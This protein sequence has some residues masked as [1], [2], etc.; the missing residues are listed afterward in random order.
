[1]SDFP[2]RIVVRCLKDG[3][4]FKGGWI[5]FTLSMRRK[6]DFHSAHGPSDEDG[7]LIVTSE[8]ILNWAD[9]ER[10]FAL[11]DFGDPRLEWSGQTRIEPIGWDLLVRARDAARGFD[12]YV[13]YPPD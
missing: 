12:N 13:S 4:P 9:S 3:L 7:I 6:N 2:G 10:S 11:M 5:Q 8:H 1:M